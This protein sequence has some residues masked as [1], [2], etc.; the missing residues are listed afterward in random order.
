MARQIM[1]ILRILCYNGSLVTY[2]AENTASIVDEA[3]LPRR[4]LPIGVLLLRML[5]P[6]GLCL[7]NRCLAMGLYVAVFTNV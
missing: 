1:P 5:S 3:C 6:S 2:I 4:C 7:L